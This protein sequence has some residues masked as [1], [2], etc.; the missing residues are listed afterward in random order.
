MLQN[1]KRFA[2][3]AKEKSRLKMRSGEGST[4]CLL[5]APPR[6]FQDVDSG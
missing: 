5:L 4:I 2:R 3:I 1:E 6:W